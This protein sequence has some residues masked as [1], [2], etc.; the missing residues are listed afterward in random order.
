MVAMQTTASNAFHLRILSSTVLLLLTS[1][2]LVG[3]QEPVTWTDQTNVVVRG[4]RLEKSGGC[5][6][7]DDAGAI[8]RQIIQSGDGAVEFRIGEA[9]TLWRAGLSRSAGGAHF[10]NIDFAVRFNGNGQADVMENGAYV[11]GD[12][13]YRAGDVFRVEVVGGRVRYLKNGQLMHA[14]QKSPTYP[15]VF[16][17]ALGSLGATVASA[18]IETRGSVVAASGI[19]DRFPR[20]DRND[21]GVISPRE[22]VGTRGGFNQRDA[23]RDGL[24]TRRERGVDEPAAVGTTGFGDFIIVN[25]TEQWTDTGLTLRPGDRVTF[26]AEGTIQ[27]SPDANDIAGPAGSRRLAP[28]APLRQQTAGTLIARIGNAAPIAVGASRTI[29]V[30]GGRLFLGINDDYVGDNSGEFR[31]VVTIEPR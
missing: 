5:D 28:D 17:V 30:G 16:D 31:V 21:D 4:G 13:G 24:L 2:P 20:L 15:L 26:N 23:N 12:T 10:G 8:S 29:S 14:S 19:D 6:G 18:Q 7:C 9:T 25:G 27:M 22:W 1:V 3:A 11:G